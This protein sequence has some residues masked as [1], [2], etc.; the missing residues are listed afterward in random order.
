MKR[1][2]F[3][4]YPGDWMR[5]TD[6]RSCSIGARGMWIDMLCLMHEGKPY[7][8]LKVG[9][10]VILLPIL[11]R[12]VGVSLPK[13]EEYLTELKSTGVC[14]IDGDGCI[15]SRRMIRDE[16]IRAKRAVGGF[17]SQNNPN[18]PRKKDKVKGYP[19]NDPNNPSLGV[20]PA[21]ASASASSN[22]KSKAL[23]IS[24]A[25]DPCPHQKIVELYHEHL[26]MLPR[27][28]ILTD[29]RKKLLKSRWLEDS[30]RQQEEWWG[31]YF[32]YISGIPFLI[33]ENDRG[34]QADYEWLLNQKKMVKIIEGG[35]ERNTNHD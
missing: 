32:K 24:K 19:S 27:V 12:I 7:G 25:A 14:S 29:A 23:V 6:L 35:Y 30:R 33:G 1:P 8:Y 34:W 18:V 3:Q 9:E 15:Y 2:S 26:P 28:K 5:S 17:D 16:E 21:S 4:F 13:A 20:S 11:A 31:R 22:T 10:M